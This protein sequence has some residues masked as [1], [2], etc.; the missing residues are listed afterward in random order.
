MLNACIGIHKHA[1]TETVKVFA[2]FLS[3]NLTFRPSEEPEFKVAGIW[4]N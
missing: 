4:W 1:K 3:L 2:G